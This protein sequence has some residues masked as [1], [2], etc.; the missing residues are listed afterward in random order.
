MLTSWRRLCRILYPRPSKSSAELVRWARDVAD[1]DDD[2]TDRSST[3]ASCT[4]ASCSEHCADNEP[5]LAPAAAGDDGRFCVSTAARKTRRQRILRKGHIAGGTRPQNSLFPCGYPGHHW[6]NLIPW[7]H[8]SSDSESVRLFWGLTVA[9]HTQIQK[10]TQTCQLHHI[11]NNRSHLMLCRAALNVAEW[12]KIIFYLKNVEIFLNVKKRDK[13][14]PC[15]FCI[16]YYCLCFVYHTFY[17]AALPTYFE[18]FERHSK[19]CKISLEYYS[20][21]HLY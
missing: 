20:K 15:N 7:T 16:R 13:H 17:Q 5:F 1:D 4:E 10:N 2:D 21:L 9:T 11:C 12:I 14:S 6:N 19:Q 18:W 8:P 3:A